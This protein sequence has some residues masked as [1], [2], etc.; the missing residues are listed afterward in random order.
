MEESPSDN[1]DDDGQSLMGSEA[2]YNE[3]C[4]DCHGSGSLAN[5]DT[6]SSCNGKGVI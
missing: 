5:N 1:K 4:P 3:L 6:C 2:K